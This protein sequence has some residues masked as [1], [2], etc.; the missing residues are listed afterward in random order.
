LT[1]KKGRQTK[2][3]LWIKICEGCE[4]SEASTEEVYQ[5]NEHESSNLR[6]EIDGSLIINNQKEEHTH[7]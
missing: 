3:A 5:F 1:S 6:E 7:C 2:I 4:G